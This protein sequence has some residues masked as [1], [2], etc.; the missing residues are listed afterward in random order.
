MCPKSAWDTCR[1]GVREYY[2]ST[3]EKDGF[4]HATKEPNMLVTIANHFYRDSPIDEEWVILVIDSDKL[5]SKVIYEP[6]APVG[7]KSSFHKDINDE[8][9]QEEIMFPHIYG[10]IQEDAVVDII[11]MARDDSGTFLEGNP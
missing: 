11:T 7:D 6:A 2:P 8:D 9:E 3:Y 4:I 5:S 1:D 10:T